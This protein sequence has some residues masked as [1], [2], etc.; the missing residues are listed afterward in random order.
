MQYQFQPMLQI[1]LDENNTAHT[2]LHNPVMD[3]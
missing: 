2:T 3:K 1:V